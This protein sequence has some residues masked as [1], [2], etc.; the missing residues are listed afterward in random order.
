MLKTVKETVCFDL[1]WKLINIDVIKTAIKH[2]DETNDAESWMNLEVC[3]E[4]VTG[5]YSNY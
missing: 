4:I 5:D 1:R 2:R 3:V